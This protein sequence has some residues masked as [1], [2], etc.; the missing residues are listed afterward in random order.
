MVG[1][2]QIKTKGAAALLTI[3]MIGGV[4]VDI[5]LAGLFVIYL[6]TQSSFGV[7]F[8]DEALSAA[9]SGVE[10]AL[11]KI[12]H[13]KN[14][15]WATSGSPYSIVVGTRTASVSINKD[16]V[17]GVLTPGKDEVYSSSTV[18]AKTRELRAVV[19]VDPITGRV[20]VESLQEVAL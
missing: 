6:L 13:N 16:I 18:F 9:Q 11:F 4:V 15:N 8:S 10:D 14:V 2:K 7:K 19:N 20:Q 17:G 3:L 1:N 12:V 5:A